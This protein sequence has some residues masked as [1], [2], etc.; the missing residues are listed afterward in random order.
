MRPSLAR[1][2]AGKQIEVQTCRGEGGSGANHAHKKAGAG[3]RRVD[4]ERL[5]GKLH[6]QNI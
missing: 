6:N 1:Q 2:A 4:I 5:A 3:I